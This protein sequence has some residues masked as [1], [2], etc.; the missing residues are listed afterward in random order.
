MNSFVVF[1]FSLLSSEHARKNLQFVIITHD[2]KFL[3]ELRRLD[4]LDTYYRVARNN[5]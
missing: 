2:D 5:K 4:T 3:E 1:I